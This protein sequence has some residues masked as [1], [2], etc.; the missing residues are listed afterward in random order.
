MP[1]LQTDWLTIGRSGHTTDG[2]MID[3]KLIEEAAQTYDPSIFTALIWP[4][5]DRFYNLGRVADVR[6][7]G[8]HEGGLDLQARLQ[9]NEIYQSAN[10]YGQKL[11]T[12]MELTRNF[13]NSGKTYLSGLGATDQPASAGLSEVRFTREAGDILRS[14][15]VEVQIQVEKPTPSL[16]TRL[17]S[18]NESQEEIIMD[19]EAVETMAAELKS[20]R[21]DVL[22]LSQQKQPEDPPKKPENPSFEERF[23]ALEAKIAEQNNPS[24]VIASLEAKISDLDQRFTAALKQEDPTGT[25]SPK[26]TGGTDINYKSVL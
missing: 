9:P 14:D 4:E 6:T 10:S 7:V 17:F 5:H 12:S 24:A 21:A 26:Q 15:P 25:K 22:K 20:L 3:A 13:R 19:R 16:F 8:N 11:F 1:K 2:R 18:R 23:A